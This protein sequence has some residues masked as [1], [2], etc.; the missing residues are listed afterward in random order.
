[1]NLQT[2]AGIE[3]LPNQ[4]LDLRIID[5]DD[6]TFLDRRRI[7]FPITYGGFVRQQDEAVPVEEFV[8]RG[9]QRLKRTS[10][11]DLE[12]CETRHLEAGRRAVPHID[13][14]PGFRLE[15]C[16][17]ESAKFGSR[18]HDQTLLTWSAGRHRSAG[19][20]WRRPTA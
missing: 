8:W 13:M 15:L 14:N 17:K 5:A 11:F 12:R 4:P 1:M 10:I 7:R 3:P 18:H 16:W 20:G 6:V 2:S 19:R 9:G